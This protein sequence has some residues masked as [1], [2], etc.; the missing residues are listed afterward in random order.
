MSCKE[1][2]DPSLFALKDFVWKASKLLI[3]N[4][5]VLKKFGIIIDWELILIKLKLTF[6][7]NKYVFLNFN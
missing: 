2:D 4:I 3:S 6:N 5:F 7:Q 1:C